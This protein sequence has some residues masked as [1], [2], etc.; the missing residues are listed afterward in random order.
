MLQIDLEVGNDLLVVHTLTIGHLIEV[1]IGFHEELWE[2][3]QIELLLH[4]SIV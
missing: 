4:H 2:V 1:F 3:I